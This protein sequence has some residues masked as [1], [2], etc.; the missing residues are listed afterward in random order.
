MAPPNT[1]AIASPIPSHYFGAIA[2]RAA[3][4]PSW[5]TALGHQQPNIAQFHDPI[6]TTPSQ[7]PSPGFGFHDP[8][9]LIPNT[10][11]PVATFGGNPPGTRLPGIGD[12]P[13]NPVATFGG[14]PPTAS[15][16]GATWLARLRR[17]G[18]GNTPVNQKV[19][20]V[21]DN[22]ATTNPVSWWL[23]H[24]RNQFATFGGNPPTIGTWTGVGGG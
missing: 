1:V 17:A 12:L 20:H 4:Y 13:F 19:R 15:T 16:W 5:Y 10:V 23:G 14:N 3:A 21:I 24:W 6:D 8:G 2:G 7:L 11:N 22:W 9:N 18:I